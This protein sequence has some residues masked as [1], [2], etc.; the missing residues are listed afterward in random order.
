MWPHHAWQAQPTWSLRVC[1][2]HFQQ[3]PQSS[4]DLKVCLT[5]PLSFLQV[6]FTMLLAFFVIVGRLET[7]NGTINSYPQIIS[8]AQV[9]FSGIWKAAPGS[10]QAGCPRSPPVVVWT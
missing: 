1:S 2:A 3:Q 8:I 5:V 10:A 4:A 7:E 9:R 6:M